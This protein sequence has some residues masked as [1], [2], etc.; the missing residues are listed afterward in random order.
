MPPLVVPDCRAV[1][2]THLRVGRACL[3][4]DIGDVRPHAL[5]EVPCSGG[6]RSWPASELVQHLRCVQLVRD[7]GEPFDDPLPRPHGTWPLGHVYDDALWGERGDA[8]CSDDRDVRSV[9]AGVNSAGHGR[10]HPL[11]RRV[12]VSVGL[13]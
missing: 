10:R 2:E 4:D 1:T 11:K 8:L 9:C 13:I 3:H 6:D 5:Q 12:D 7:V